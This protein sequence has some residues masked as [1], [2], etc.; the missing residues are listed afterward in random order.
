[1]TIPWGQAVGYVVTV[2]IAV[3]ARRADRR[4]L[5]RIVTQVRRLTTRSWIRGAQVTHV[6]S[7]KTGGEAFVPPEPPRADP[8]APRE[9]VGQP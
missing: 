8:P 3:T 5:E 1:M 6:E 2:Q 4:T 9:E 7:L